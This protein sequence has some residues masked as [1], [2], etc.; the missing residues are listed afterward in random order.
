MTSVITWPVVA[1]HSVHHAHVGVRVGKHELFPRTVPG[2][3]AH[4]RRHNQRVS[5]AVGLRAGAMAA[6]QQE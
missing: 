4:Q 2:I 1:Q 6:E 5:V 3:T